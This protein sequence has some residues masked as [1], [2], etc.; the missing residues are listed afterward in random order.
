MNYWLLKS[1][2]GCYSFDRQKK[3]GITHWDGVKN[4]QA[5]NNMKS[6]ALGDVCFFYHSITGKEIVGLVRV[7]KE[8]YP[9][10]SDE[11]FVWVD[12]A[13]EGTF[14]KSIPLSEIK[15]RWPH[16]PLVKQSRLSVMPIESYDFHAICA[17]A[18]YPSTSLL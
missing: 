10:P 13:Y 14:E 17:W 1:E 5:R 8:N 4:Y 6:M 16:L 2:P 15:I 11:R 12:V 9:D 7:V 3:E 18:G